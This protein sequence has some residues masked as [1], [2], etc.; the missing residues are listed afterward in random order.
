MRIFSNQAMSIEGL[1]HFLISGLPAKAAT[2]TCPKHYDA[3]DTDVAE[4]L[5]II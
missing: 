3:E 5:D 2:L 4:A 1:A